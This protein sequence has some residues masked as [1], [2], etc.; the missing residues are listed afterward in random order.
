MILYSI[1]LGLPWGVAAF[2]QT[3]VLY[4]F[5]NKA[6]RMNTSTFHG[7]LDLIFAIDTDSPLK[8][9]SVIDSQ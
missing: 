4:V 1:I 3:Q 7:C 6:I 5:G 8:S 2:V 9:S